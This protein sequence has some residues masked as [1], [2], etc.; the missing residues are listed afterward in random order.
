MCE[1][2]R[3]DPCYSTAEPPSKR[4]ANAK[5]QVICG[6]VYQKYCLKHQLYL[7]K[8]MIQTVF[9]ACEVEKYLAEPLLDFKG[10]SPFKWW[11]A[12]CNAY[13]LLCELARK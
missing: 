13:I 11:A 9:H 3:N 2:E 7:M 1:N 5:V 4:P 10:N 6:V 8:V 12:N